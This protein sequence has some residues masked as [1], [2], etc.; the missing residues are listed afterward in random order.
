[1]S[2]VAPPPPPPS[3]HD[4]AAHDY[5]VHV[6]RHFNAVKAILP[7]YQLGFAAQDG[8]VAC[9]TR[10]LAENYDPMGTSN[11]G[12]VAMD[13]AGYGKM[14]NNVDTDEVMGIIKAAG[15]TFSGHDPRSCQPEFAE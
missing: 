12:W 11:S 2:L 6:P 9:V 10:M 14:Q 13:W 1:V 5:A 8:C 3:A 4:N 15:G 7:Q